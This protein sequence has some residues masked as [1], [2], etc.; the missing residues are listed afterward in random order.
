MRMSF[1]ICC[2]LVLIGSACAGVKEAPAVDVKVDK[3][4]DTWPLY[5]LCADMYDAKKRTL[6][7]Q[8]QL[9]DELGYEGYGHL[10]LGDVAERVR[11]LDLV[12]RRLFQVYVTVDLSKPV[13]F[14]EK[15][16]VEALPL[17]KPHRTQ[18]ALLIQGGNPSDSKLDDKAMA[19]INRI[20]DL[21]K[22]YNVTVVLY[23]H[24]KT[25][26]PKPAMRFVLQPKLTN[27][28]R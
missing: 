17:L 27:P 15:A 1:S 9:I 26:I 14:N 7:Q 5:V 22:P 28:A 23:P 4:K 8:A 2:V 16:L 20:A 21:A 6:D 11:T 19:V 10:W 3:S 25:W 12:K 18:L 13:P 24:C